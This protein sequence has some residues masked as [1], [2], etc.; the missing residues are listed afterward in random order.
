VIFRQAVWTF[1]TPQGRVLF[2]NRRKDI[3]TPGLELIPGYTQ[4][5]RAAEKNLILILDVTSGLFYSSVTLVELLQI[6]FKHKQVTRLTSQDLFQ[7]ERVLRNLNVHPNYQ[8]NVGRKSYK[9]NGLT[10]LGADSTYFSYLGQNMSVAEYFAKEYN[11]VLEYPGLPCIIATIGANRKP[12]NGTESEIP[13]QIYLP[14][15][16]C[17]LVANQKVTRPLGNID[18]RGFKPSALRPEER[19]EHISKAVELVYSPCPTL[20]DSFKLDLDFKML[21][22]AGR[23]LPAPKLL[24]HA[25]SREPTVTPRDGRWNMDQHKVYRGVTIARW[26]VLP[27]VTVD[28]TQ[29]AKFMLRW[30]GVMR[31]MGMH[32]LNPKPTILPAAD[33]NTSIEVAIQHC[34]LQSE[35]VHPD[36]LVFILPDRSTFGNRLFIR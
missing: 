30:T 31:E 9:I 3:T 18:I 28:P 23:T 12:V 29:V 32:V 21:E 36:V 11:R 6:A 27:F 15:E 33:P 13:S 24:F 1:L 26:A 25:S 10:K 20:L 14:L 19:A 2:D 8:A 17:T 16:L 22:I 4:A 35:P 34:Y 7:A 5:I